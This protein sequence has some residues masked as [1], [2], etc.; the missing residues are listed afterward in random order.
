[1]KRL[2]LTLFLGPTVGLSF[3]TTQ[4]PLLVTHIYGITSAWIGEGGCP[5]VVNNTSAVS[6]Q[7]DFSAIYVTGAGSWTA[8]LNFSDISCGGPWTSYGSAASITQGSP[9]P[10]AYGYGYHKY[11]QIVIT[12]AAT[13]TYSASKGYYTSSVASSVVF[14]ISWITQVGNQ[15]I[16]DLRTYGALCNGSA[17]DTTAVTTVEATSYEVVSIPYGTCKVATATL[18]AVAKHYIGPGKLI[19][20]SSGV[21]FAPNHS[22]VRSKPSSGGC[23]TTRGSCPTAYQGD[24]RWVDA[25]YFQV[26]SSANIASFTSN[27]YNYEVNPFYIV[28]KSESGSGDVVAWTHGQSSSGQK[29][30][31]VNATS[32]ASPGQTVKVATDFYVV[33]TIQ[34]GVSLTM[35]T[36]LTS[37][38]GTVGDTVKTALYAANRT[39]QSTFFVEHW[40]TGGGDSQAFFANLYANVTSSEG[41]THTSF[42]GSTTLL[43]GGITAVQ[44]WNALAGTEIQFTDA[45][46]QGNTYKATAVG[47]VRNFNRFLW[48]GY[49]DTVASGSTVDWVAGGKFD[50]TWVGGGATAITIGAS[51]YTIASVVSST[52]LILTGAVPDQKGVYYRVDPAISVNGAWTGAYYS[53]NGTQYCEGL[54]YGTGKWKEGI[55]LSGLT[56]DA[57]KAAIILGADHRVYMNGSSTN[58]SDVGYSLWAKTPGTE[59]FSYNTALSQ[60]QWWTGGVQ[61]MSLTGGAYPTLYT[62][63]LS[64]TGYATML[65]ASMHSTAT[66]STD[67]NYIATESGASNAIVASLVDNPGANVPT[68]A[69]LC[70]KVKLGHTLQAGANTFALNGGTAVSIKSNRNSAN[71]IAAVWAIGGI[72][73][74]CY[75]GTVWRD[76]TQ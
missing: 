17:D 25:R 50:T 11:I 28:H 66:T 57:S 6:R 19:D 9:T 72:V 1:M 76:M 13:A 34:A 52:E 26:T 36:N 42:V 51:N 48:A 10:I 16:V 5:G 38:Y 67:W 68:A 74:L 63:Y 18:A 15:P 49:V 46:W 56:L 44:N 14:P 22:I 30:L 7:N 21:S 37:T 32:W 27:Y 53:C 35:T 75:D 24:Q 45:D 3:Q 59:W 62:S 58:D 29:I 69:G 4:Q 39:S 33:D 71:N 73:P 54:L 43:G 12:G 20:G 23:S 8:A 65:G 61:T 47:D 40:N 2:L 64:L 70:V 41:A 60:W 55:A 31:T